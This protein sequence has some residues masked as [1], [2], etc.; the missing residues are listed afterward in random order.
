LSKSDQ[1]AQKFGANLA[2]TISLRA[3]GASRPPVPLTTPDKFEGAIKSRAFAE[4][5]VDAVERDESQPRTEFDSEDLRRLASSIA[6]FGQLSPIRVRRDEAK[7]RWVVLVGERRLR[8][9]KLAGL[10][11]VR[12]EFV[13]R[14]MTEAD[15]LAEQTVENVVRADLLP[16]E[17]GRAYKRLMDLHGWTAKDLSETI[18]VEPTSVYRSLALLRLPEDVA[19]RVDSG[20]IK[21][22][23]AYEIAKLQIAVDQR[24]VADAVVSKDMDHKATVDAV[25]RRRAS[26]KGRGASKGRGGKVAPKL[27][28]ERTI[29]TSSGLK[30]VVSARK[31]FD[32]LTLVE[33]LGQALATIRAELEAAGVSNEGEV[34]IS[35]ATALDL[36]SNSQRLSGN[37]NRV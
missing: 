8:A 25:A 11:R 27:P 16:V 4:L 37:E 26:S 28:T 20:E 23:A 7:G 9:C 33:S 29:K 15:V 21:A 34:T 2:Q 30:V 12:V 17:Q 5:P 6:R 36:E 3:D 10:E 19:E 1:L 35:L 32:L 31:G 13:E 24:A 14:E 18:G 22:T